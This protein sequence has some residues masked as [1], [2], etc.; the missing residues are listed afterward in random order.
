M[1]KLILS[2]LVGSVVCH[3]FHSNPAAASAFALIEQGVK[4][5]GNAYAGGAASADDASTVFFNPAG[6]TRLSGRQFAVAGHLVTPSA[7]LLGVM[8][9]RQ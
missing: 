3:A 8:S 2:F 1:K 4:G 7:K 9:I 6:M 5:L